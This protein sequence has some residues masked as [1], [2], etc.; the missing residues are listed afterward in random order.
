MT[1]VIDASLIDRLFE[2]IAS[3]LNQI[4]PAEQR[5]VARSLRMLYLFPDEIEP[6]LA[7]LADKSGNPDEIIRKGAAILP[8]IAI[9]NDELRFLTSDSLRTNLRLS[10]EDVE[11]IRSLASMKT[12]VR[13]GFASIFFIW[14]FERN[15]DEVSEIA[16]DLLKQIKTFNEHI[17]RIENK[18]HQSL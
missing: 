6:L 16:A 17:K 5:R 11:S 12:G 8:D 4:E 10:L 13:S 2:K 18:V 7:S 15:V 3:A 9:A 1:P 14:T